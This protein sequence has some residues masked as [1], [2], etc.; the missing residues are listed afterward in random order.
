MI[1]TQMLSL[2]GLSERF[3]AAC[4]QMEKLINVLGLLTTSFLEDLAE[5]NMRVLGLVAASSD[6]LESY[7]AR[8]KL[9]PKSMAGLLVHAFRAI[10]SASQKEKGSMKKPAK[11]CDIVELRGATGYSDLATI[12]LWLAPTKVSLS[13]R[14]STE[15]PCT[16]KYS[17]GNETNPLVLQIAP[18]ELQEKE[19]GSGWSRIPWSS[20]KSI[21]NDALSWVGVAKPLLKG[22]AGL[23]GGVALSAAK[24]LLA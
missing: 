2:S 8:K 11:D 20:V 10:L 17:I 22:P 24:K 16:R 12:L 23:F 18:Q 21:A 15:H 6:L 14:Y 13:L 4:Q 19:T 3:P 5:C 1:V 9:A 7:G